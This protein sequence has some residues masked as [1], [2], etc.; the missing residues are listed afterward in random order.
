MKK[1]RLR[2]SDFLLV[3]TVLCA[4]AS[5]L[6][7]VSCS[8]GERNSRIEASG[9][10]EVRQV[11]LAAKVSGEIVDLT[12]EEGAA[13]EPG[14]IQ[15]RIDHSG[16]DIQ[17]RQ[18]GAGAELARAQLDLLLAGAR[19]E[20][21]RQAEERLSQ[22]ETSLRTAEADF[23][24]MSE[25]EKTGSV[26]PKQREDAEARYNVL[27]AQRNAAAE[28]AAKMKQ[29]A[30]PEEIRAARARLA[31]AGAQVD[32]LAKMVSDSTVYSPVAGTVTGRPVEKGEFVTPGTTLLTVSALDEVF[33]MLYVT[34]EELGRIKLGSP[35][36]VSIDSFPEKKF[37]GRVTYI[38]PEAEFTP[39]NIQ[40]KDDRVK[41]VFGVK[42][43]IPNPE[44]LLKPGLPADAVIETGGSGV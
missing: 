21:I 7:S 25:L 35:V 32:L 43:E 39:K 29:L 42:V 2:L 18:A 9:T 27:L 12:V 26:P 44:G 33:V 10:I 3:L 20:D 4:A 41:L 13:V 28:A 36:E 1:Q 38:S 22:A 40:T 17:L 31:Q 8:D 24:R 37:P 23:R 14:A 30:R 34:A 11:N 16:L 5:F 19:K 6:L 15:A